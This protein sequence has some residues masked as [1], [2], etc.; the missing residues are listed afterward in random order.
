MITPRPE[1]RHPLSPYLQM[2]KLS[3]PEQIVEM[4]GTAIANKLAARNTPDYSLVNFLP[5]KEVAKLLDLSEDRV[6]HLYYESKIAG[7]KCGKNLYFKPEWISEYIQS[8]EHR[9]K[10]L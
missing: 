3:S 8:G 9:K 5:L 7:T 10:L 1:I 6:R 2:E 4:L